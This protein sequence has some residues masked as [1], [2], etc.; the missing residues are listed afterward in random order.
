MTT[1]AKASSGITLSTDRSGDAVESA[2]RIALPHQT[3]TKK[4][5][6]AATVV[7]RIFMVEL[8]GKA[9]KGNRLGL[10]NC[11]T[12]RN[13]RA[14]SGAPHSIPGNHRGPAIERK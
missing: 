6:A 3:T 13:S 9:W 10:C 11:A 1:T 7:R 4:K 14:P 5:N 8:L 12:A 2:A